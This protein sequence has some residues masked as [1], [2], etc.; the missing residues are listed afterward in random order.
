MTIKSRVS[1]MLSLVA[2]V[3]VVTGIYLFSALS[4]AEDDAEII[5]AL[6]RQRMLSQA[7]AKSVL[8]Y[9]SGKQTVENVK[10]RVAS[11]DRYI[12]SMRG[13]YTASVISVAKKSGVA[14]SMTPKSEPHPAVPFPATFA[15]LVN[16][17]A[18]SGDGASTVILSDAPVNPDSA[19]QTA[20]DREATEFLE[21]DTKA[22]FFKPEEING[23]MSLTFYTADTAVAQ[24]CVSCHTAMEG[25]PYKLGDML[26][27]RRYRIPF[28]ASMASGQQLL[29]PSLAEYETAKMIFTTTLAAMKSGGE[30]PT[31]LAGK[32]FRTVSAI[33]DEAAQEL[34]GEVTV[35]FAAM[36]E[37]TGKIL[38]GKAAQV[39]ALKL[40]TQANQLRSASNA[41]VMRFGAI[42]A[43]HQDRIKT[44]IVIATIITLAT[45]IGVFLFMKR[46]VI[47][48]IGSLSDAMGALAEGDKDTQ[49]NYA[50]DS[51]EIGDM[52]R[53]VQVFKDNMLRND[54]LVAEQ[55]Q[56]RAVREER[57]R[58]V[59]QL[60]G[61]FDTTV[62]DVL[63]GVS[64]AATQMD[65]TA[66]TMS[67]TAEQTVQQATSVAAASEQASV[68]V[69][70][71]ATASE[72]MSSSID[73][74]TRQVT[75]SA[76]ITAEAVEQA[77]NTNKTMVGLNDSAQKIGDVVGLI[78]DIASQTNLLA[79][80]A[81]IEAARA[82]EAG[83]GFA[84]VASEVKNLAT[85][86]AK[87]TEEIGSQIAAMQSE[88]TGALEALT[89]IG[90]TIET[91]NEIA[92]TISS[93]VEEQSAA[94]QEISRNVD[95]AAQGTQ[96]VSSTISSIS[97]AT[98]DTGVAAT[99]VVTA[100][101]ELSQQSES[102]KSTVEKFLGDV[103]S[104]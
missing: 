90:K 63:R 97:Q 101:E 89:G 48:R 60:A 10:T 14:I 54:E 24:G 73:E 49:I 82:G 75:D 34:V 92:T 67:K 23:G 27:I 84:V 19:L 91:V 58:K 80:N 45:I 78:N 65:A 32:N 98:S 40:G 31:D 50:E 3:S 39:E 20:L 1:I 12:T 9:A 52:A 29:N 35:A 83:K 51:D 42:A 53:A 64:A 37:S 81:T 2:A 74:I 16:A 11:L 102:L 26:G 62:S 28:A 41:L 25:R 43:G 86:T 59:E 55:E 104:A 71:V 8:G 15:R 99:Q 44:A 69:Q 7:M 46:A 33:D 18:D 93:A 85:Q 76:R 47:G 100:S 17:K 13:Q 87:A 56:E 38:S 68:N 36:E 21:K 30:Y 95:Q 61:E 88:T 103:R 22:V 79:L 57:A 94:T 4:A 77:E 72:E 96:E 66:K 70:T 5:D 6:G